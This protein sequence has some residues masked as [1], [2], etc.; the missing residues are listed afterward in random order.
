[1]KLHLNR[2]LLRNFFTSASLLLSVNGQILVTLCQGQSGTP[3]DTI[4]RKKGDT[5]QIIDMASFA[6]LVL[7]K[8]HPFCSA[9]WPL[10]NSNGYRG[11][12][13]GFHVNGAYTFAFHKVPLIVEIKAIKQEEF[14]NLHCPYVQKC[15][16]QQKNCVFQEVHL[17]SH[18]FKTKPETLKVCNTVQTVCLCLQKAGG[19]N[20]WELVMKENHYDITCFLLCYPC[21]MGNLEPVRKVIVINGTREFTVSLL[22]FLDLRCARRL[23]EKLNEDFASIFHY[24]E[25]G[26]DLEVATIFEKKSKENMTQVAIYVDAFL[27]LT[28]NFCV[29]QLPFCL[30]LSDV[31]VSSLHPPAHCHHLCFW[32]SDDFSTSRFSC[33]LRYAAGDFIRSFQLIDEY[34]CPVKKQKSLCY[35]ITYQSFHGALSSEKAFYLQT[36]VIGPFLQECL[37]VTIR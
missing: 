24:K 16:D 18:L 21:Y 22:N 23:E 9:D 25:V 6:D 4:K 29:P 11:L 34:Y 14:N 2:Q 32:I 13:K 20:W 36:K 35:Q 3:Y 15:L 5:W 10:Y 28:T 12:E 31:V 30:D 1:M 17:F 27:R 26:N 37:D 8:V 19:I 7:M 33:S